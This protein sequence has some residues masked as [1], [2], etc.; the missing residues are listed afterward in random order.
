MQPNSNNIVVLRAEEEWQRA[1]AYSVRIQ[2]MNRLHHISL[3]E[4]FD[5]HDGDGTKYIVLLDAGYPVAT[6]RFFETVPGHVTLGRV[7]VL[8]EYRG[9]KLGVMAVCEAEKWIAECGYSVIDIESRIEAV[10]FY[11]KLGY[12]RV[13]NS[14]VRSGVFDCIRMWKSLPAR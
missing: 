8:S 12:V 7:V 9:R 1:G 14:V 6:C 3:R 13:D 11:E 5:E 2:G 10:Q 4:E